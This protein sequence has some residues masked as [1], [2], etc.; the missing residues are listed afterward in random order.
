MHNL[1]LV[2]YEPHWTIPIDCEVRSL[3]VEKIYRHRIDFRGTRD[4]SRLEEREILHIVHH[5]GETERYVVHDS[6]QFYVIL[7]DPVAVG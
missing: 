7:A 1:T 5:D 6:T 2:I 3:R 4:R